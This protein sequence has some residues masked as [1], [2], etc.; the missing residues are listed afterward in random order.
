VTEGLTLTQG[1]IREL[2][3]AAAAIKSGLRLVLEAN[4]LA[5]GELDA[6]YIAGAFGTSLDV[7]NAVRIGLLPRLAAGRIVFVGNASL[8]GARA[9][10]L[11][12]P[13]RRRAERLA[14]SVRHLSLA[15]GGSFERTFVEA[16][17]FKPWPELEK[18]ARS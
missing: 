3:L 12:R 14:R 4:D 9:L 6:M 15:L 2:Q 16:L 18:E 10:L 17:E 1:D 5:F 8:A 7:D 11:V 13:E